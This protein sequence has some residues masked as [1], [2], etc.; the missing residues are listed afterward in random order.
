MPLYQKNLPLLLK[1]QL[2]M[3]MEL[4]KNIINKAVKK[5]LKEPLLKMD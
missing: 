3:K 1:I 5:S 2:I 4:Q